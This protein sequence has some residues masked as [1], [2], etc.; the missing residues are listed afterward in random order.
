MKPRISVISLGVADLARSRA[1]YCDGLG[2]EPRPESGDRAVFL[3]LEGTWLSLFRRDRLAQMAH[4]SPD[5]A[6]FSGVVL[7]HN[8]ATADEV[9]EVM[10]LA[11]KAGGSLAVPAEDRPFGRIA[12]FADPDGYLWEV[13]WTPQ[14]PE[15]TP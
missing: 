14:W 3:Q 11:L 9:D 4:V 8:V 5:G 13:A 2:F 7:S 12:Y 6:G 15:L 1:F 10:A